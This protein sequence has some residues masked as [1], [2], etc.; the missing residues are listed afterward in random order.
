MKTLINQTKMILERTANNC[1]YY[2]REGMTEHLIN[3]VGC[4]RGIM[5]VADEIGIE[6]PLNLYYKFYI[7][8]VSE[9]INEHEPPKW[10]NIPTSTDPV[11]DT[12]KEGA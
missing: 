4:L 7:Q 1:D 5:Y 12:D 8:P 10:A 11:E 9:L 2:K 3:E 6:Y